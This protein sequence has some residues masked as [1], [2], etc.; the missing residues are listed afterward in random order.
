MAALIARSNLALI[1][2]IYYLL[3]AAFPIVSMRAYEEVF[4]RQESHWLVKTHGLMDGAIGLVLAWAGLRKSASP[5]IPV[6]GMAAALGLAVP[7]SYYV[8]SRRI[9]AAYLLDILPQLAFAGL[10]G[11]LLSRSAVGRR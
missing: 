11:W 2:G 3:T 7:E 6:L 1:Q 8:A 9:S 10:W 5:E 4:G